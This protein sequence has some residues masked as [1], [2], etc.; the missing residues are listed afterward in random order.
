[1]NAPYIIIFGILGTLA[2]FVVAEWFWAMGDTRLQPLGIVFV[3]I[4]PILAWQDLLRGGR[5]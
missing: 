2:G 5:E 1:M 4:C 3:A